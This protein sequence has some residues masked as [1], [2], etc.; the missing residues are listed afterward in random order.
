M[1]PAMFGQVMPRLAPCMA[2]VVETCWRQAPDP[3]ASPSRC[4]LLAEVAR[5]NGASIAYRFGQDRLPLPRF[6]GW[7]PWADAPWRQEVTRQ[8][9]APLGHADGVLGFDPSRVP[10]SGP[11]AV[12]VARQ[13][14]GRRGKGDHGQ[15]AGALGS[16]S[17][18][19]PTLVAMRRSLPSAWTTDQARLDNAGVPATH[20]GSRSRPQVAL[21]RLQVRGPRL[22][23]GGMA[24]EDEMG[25]PYGWR[26]RLERL[27]EGSRLAVPGNPLM[28]ALA[29]A[30][31]AA[32]GRGRHP[33]RP[34]QRRDP[35]STALTQ[36]AWPPIDVRD[37]ATGPLVVEIVTGPVVARPPP[38]Q[39]GHQERAVVGR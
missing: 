4:G 15:G 22:P 11:A 2:P 34:W 10:T 38:R 21:A 19:G 8:S 9:A 3:P 1:P 13:W 36:D 29:P 18:K 28:R 7:A 32:S 31:P 16:V 14:W 12:G 24:G 6:M 35:W 17:G 23:H 25:R 30:P 33:Q 26:R 39:E 37:G 27:G 20:R 5:K